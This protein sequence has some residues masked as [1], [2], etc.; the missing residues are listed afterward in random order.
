MNIKPCS[1]PFSSLKYAFERSVVA[2][3]FKQLYFFEIFSE[4]YLVV[5]GL[6]VVILKKS[7]ILIEKFS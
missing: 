2:Y 7:K 3:K 4:I 1:Y 6:K 5:C